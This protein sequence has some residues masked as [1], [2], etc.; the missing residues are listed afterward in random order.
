MRI[1][2][3]SAD[4]LAKTYTDITVKCDCSHSVVLRHSVAKT[5]CSVCGRTVYNK[6]PM[7]EQ[8]RQQDIE[9]KNKHKKSVFKRNLQ[10]AIENG[11]D[12]EYGIKT[13]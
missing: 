5:T 2:K 9:R 13:N 7:G 11:K 6:T 1:W 8:A 10:R 4:R 3:N 12:Q